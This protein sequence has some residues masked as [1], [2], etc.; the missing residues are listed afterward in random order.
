[1]TFDCFAEG[2]VFPSAAAPPRIE[3]G[4]PATS[5]SAEVAKAP[6]STP[7]DRYLLVCLY[8]MVMTGFGT[9]AATG[10]LDIASVIFVSAALLWRG[11]LLLIHKNL[12]L[13]ERWNTR[14]ALGFVLF[15]LV[16]VFLGSRSFLT[17]TVHLVMCGLV[18]K[19]FS[20]LRDRDYV[21]LASLS[22]AMVLAASVLTVDSTFFLALCVFLLMAVGT[23]IL[24][25]M[26]RAAAQAT[27]RAPGQES[28]GLERQLALS[29]GGAAPVILLFILGGAAGIFFVLPRVSGGYAGAYST[30]TDISTGFSNEVRLGSIGEIQQSDAVVMHVQM[31]SGSVASQEFKWRGV[32]L[33]SFNGATWF[34]RD[35]R[36]VARRLADGRYLTSPS[37]PATRDNLLR[38]RVVLEPLSSNLFFLAEQ[39][40]TVSGNYSLVAFDKGGAVFDMDREHPIGVYEGESDATR[41]TPAELRASA[42]TYPAEIPRIYLQLPDVDPRIVQM[43]QEVTRKAG[44]NYDKAV[45]LENHLRSHYGYTL[46]LP[47]TTPKDPLANFL[48]ERKQGHCEYFASAM[49]V[50]LRSIGIPSRV[51]NGFRGGEFNDFSG[52]YLIRA[53]DAHSWVEAY[54]PGEG[55][56]SFDPTPAGSVVPSHGGWNRIVLYLDAMTSFWREWIVNY[57]FAHQRSLGE[58]GARRGRLLLEHLRQRIVQPYARLLNAARAAHGRAS[59]L[60]TAWVPAAAGLACL[61]LLLANATRL[62][63]WSQRLSWARRSTKAPQ[64]AATLWYERMTKALGRRGWHKTPEQTAAEFVEDIPDA[65]VRESVDNFTRHYERARFAASTEDAERLPELYE[66]ITTDSR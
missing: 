8:L 3:G 56:I 65:A 4:M 24:L 15:Y 52:K 46:R 6:S 18:V 12:V 55:W 30:G 38:Y 26:H 47:V 40:A 5:A 7:V 11:Y 9:L 1:V 50:M 21:L 22:F 59:R 29:L 62:R 25:Q 60:S 19:I 48:F 42:G 51:V 33:S 54:F 13:P 31:E 41:P 53:R 66:E 10:Q 35:E 34:S 43:A 45:A 16:D 2:L 44:N 23:S 20:P 28:H 14:L 58:D 61:F 32:A 17:A 64:I 36:I 49:A 39:P 37:L 27:Q 57:D 63:R